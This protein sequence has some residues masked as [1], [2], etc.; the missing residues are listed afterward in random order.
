M[1][2]FKKDLNIA[3][4]IPA[5]GGSKGIPNKNIVSICGHPLI[6]WSINQAIAS[7]RISSVWVTSDDQKIL[8]I[9]KQYGSNIIERPSELATDISSSESAWIHS[10]DYLSDLKIFPDLVVGMQA[11]SPIRD[12][13]D[14]D[15]AIEN[16]IINDYE[17]LFTAS[18]LEDYFMW[19]IDKN[20]NP[21][22]L[23]YDMNKRKPRHQISKSYLENGSFYI[24]KPE[25]IKKFNNRL[26]GKIGIYIMA[27]YKSFQIDNME[28]IKI[29]TAIMKEY[30]LKI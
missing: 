8:D 19:G 4:I 6:S 17:S 13:E 14:L 16:F 23:N 18:K 15:N 27:K 28:D 12:H 30:D 20:L 21:S 10:I 3:A 24:F 2:S 26:Y 25:S 9:S 5:R 22:P 29:C 1:G 11:T 7:K